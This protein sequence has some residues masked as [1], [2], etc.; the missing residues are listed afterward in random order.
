MLITC[1]L[2]AILG[3][4]PGDGSEPRT[5]FRPEMFETLVN[6]AC[7]HCIDES[8]RKAG[9]S[10]MTTACW[11]GFAASMTA[12]RYPTAGSSSLIV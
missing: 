5:L 9:A 4:E 11:P 8:R 12:A 2:F 6:P 1:L 7:S 10:A 3:A